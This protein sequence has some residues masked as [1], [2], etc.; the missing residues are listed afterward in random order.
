MIVRRVYRLP[1]Q[2]ELSVPGVIHAHEAEELIRDFVRKLEDRGGVYLKGTPPEIMYQGFLIDDGGA[3]FLRA[4]DDPALNADDDE[5]D[6]DD[7]QDEDEDEDES[8]GR[9]AIGRR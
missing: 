2:L 4:D 9:D 5:N 6:E 8:D 7:E 3:K 1:V